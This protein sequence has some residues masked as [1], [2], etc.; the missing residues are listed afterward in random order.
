ML[1]VAPAAA[2]P[3]VE[4]VRRVRTRDVGALRTLY[5]RHGGAVLT[6][7][8]VMAHHRRGVD[9]EQATVDVFVALWDA[10]PAP[11][12]AECLRGLLVR[13]LG[14]LAVIHNAEGSVFTW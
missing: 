4:L 8:R 2:L 9:P 6:A 7:A 13:M 10:P 3:D 12:E 11:A 5:Q 1:T 14:R